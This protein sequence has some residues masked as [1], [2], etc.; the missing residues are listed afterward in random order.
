VSLS[1]VDGGKIN[2]VRADCYICRSRLLSFGGFYNFGLLGITE[3]KKLKSL[4]LAKNRHLNE[5]I[6]INSLDVFR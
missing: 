2:Y 5:E 3:D 6:R 1:G 4:I